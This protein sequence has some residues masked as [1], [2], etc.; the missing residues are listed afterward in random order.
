MKKLFRRTLII[1]STG[2]VLICAALYLKQ[3]SLIFY[4]DVLPANYT[5]S[6][7]QPFKEIPIKTKDG[8]TLSSVLFTTDRPKGVIFY[9]H[10]NAGA[11]DSW[12]DVAKTYTALQYDVFMVDYR[13]YGKSQ[14][15]ITSQQQMFDDIQA[16][17]DTLKTRYAEDKIIVLGYS[18]GTGP[19][20]HI[21]AT[22]KP[23][24]LILQAPYYSLTDMM[25]HTY[26]VIPTFIL[27]YK[28][29]TSD[30]LKQCTMPVTIFHGDADEVIY[31]G[32]SLKL[33]KL[34]K[35]GD[36]LITLHNQGHNGITGN[37][38]YQAALTKILNEK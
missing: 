5:F 18:I 21:A 30:Y 10:G 7:L 15:S 20:A 12:G 16:A 17:Y 8:T 11:L 27:K 29:P 9:L 24:R 38:E 22:N 23:G 19:A 32:S 28:L 2:Y 14:G 34:F 36:T 35:S 26:P 1:I 13:G 6:F 33:Q 4:P 25:L 31:Y 37:G 3:E